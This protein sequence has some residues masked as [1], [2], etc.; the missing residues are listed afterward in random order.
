MRCDTESQ[1]W[2]TRM[3]N[4]GCCF[5][6][7]SL[8]RSITISLPHHN[9]LLS[10]VL[11]HIIQRCE[12]GGCCL[13]LTSQLCSTYNDAFRHY[14]IIPNKSSSNNQPSGFLF[15][16]LPQA[17]TLVG[18]HTSIFV[19]N[20]QASLAFYSLL[21]F[22]PELKFITNDARATWISSSWF[23]Q[24][25]IELIELPPE[26]TMQGPNLM[27]ASQL[28]VGLYHISLDVTRLCVDINDFIHYIQA[29][30][31]K[32]F[33]K[34]IMVLLPPKQQMMG[35]LVVQMAYIKDPN[36]VILELIRRQTLLTH[37]MNL[38]VDF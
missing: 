1:A 35:R 13:L 28:P 33:D 29:D 15:W 19:S 34:S 22:Q 7:P 32:R 20:I 6:L 10:E 25:R 5:L 8:Y 31:M 3:T 37:E 16:P 30:S 14:N 17:Q 27:A 36:G 2:I 24:Q 26:R 9:H 18:G 23:P 11:D 4:I 12:R 38:E 21:G